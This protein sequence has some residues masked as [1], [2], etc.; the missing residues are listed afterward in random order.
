M[1]FEQ[2][3]KKISPILKRITFKLDG[4]SISFNHEDLYQEALVHLW[5]D[6]NAG[7]LRHKTDSYILQGCYFYL[8]NYIRKTRTKTK[9]V[10]I[11]ETFDNEDVSFQGMLLEDKN[12]TRYFDYLNDKM[13][14]EVI[15]NNGLEPREKHILSL[16]A[17]GLTVREIGKK[18]GVSHVRVVKL[19]KRIKDKCKKYID[20]I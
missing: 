13:L 7:K 20:A 1:P 15:Q 10:S 3:L 19:T 6:F 8:K 5:Q 14:V 12:S 4:N 18:L 17:Q 11:E 2:L 9:L 16:Y